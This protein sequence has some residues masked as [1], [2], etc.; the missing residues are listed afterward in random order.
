MKIKANF[1]Q[2]PQEG[3]SLS[4][5]YL[6]GTLILLPQMEWTPIC[7]DSKEGQISLQWSAVIAVSYIISQDEGIP[8]TPVE[9][10][11]KVLGALLI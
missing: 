8:E 5:R 1:I 11:E 10:L 7:P 6:R 3:A 4:N 2:V 9:T